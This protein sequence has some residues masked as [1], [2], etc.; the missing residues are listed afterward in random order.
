MVVWMREVRVEVIRNAF[1]R[2]KV[3]HSWIEYKGGK[4]RS[5]VCVQ[6]F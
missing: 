6:G 1:G 2:S 4:K 3:T 5:Q